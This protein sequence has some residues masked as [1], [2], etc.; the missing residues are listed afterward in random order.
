M[1][2]DY[3][4]MRLSLALSFLTLAVVIVFATAPQIDLW[5]SAFYYDSQLGFWRNN[6]FE[7]NLLRNILRRSAEVATALTFI[8]ALGNLFLGEKQRTGWR[9]WAFLSGSV[10]VCS[11]LLVNGILKQEIGRVRPAYI[12]DFGGTMAFTP[13]FQIGGQCQANCSFTSGESSLVATLLLA[14]CVL[15]WPH[16]R[17]R[18]RGIMIIAAAAAVAATGV[19]RIAMGRHFLQRCPVV[20]RSSPA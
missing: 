13:P 12:L 3:L 1:E 4:Y 18:G 14:F 11:G 6:S 17:P 19:L 20:G 15:V 9:V 2:P 7:Y 16:A 8:M 5:V 10:L